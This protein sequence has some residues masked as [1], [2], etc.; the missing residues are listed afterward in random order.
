MLWELGV[1]G[2]RKL[3]ITEDKAYLTNQREGQQRRK[4]MKVI[5]E[6]IISL[7]DDLKYSS[8]SAMRESQN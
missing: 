2:K 7:N 5:A 4:S 3:I 8:P 6:S 1:G